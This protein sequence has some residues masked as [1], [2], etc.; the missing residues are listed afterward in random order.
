M[1]ITDLLAQDTFLVVNKKIAKEYGLEVSI[2]L[3]ELAYEYNYWKDREQLENDYFYSTI[4]NIQENTTLT[5]YQQTKALNK[6]KELN[7]IDYKIQGIPPKRYIKVYSDNIFLILENKKSN[8]GKTKVKNWKIKSQKLETNNNNI[9][10]INNNN[11]KYKNFTERDLTDLD[12]F[13]KNI[14]DN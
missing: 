2:M 3:S 9:K 5:K 11:K 10:I 14:G 13:Y 12:K 8:I 4:E 6:L 7:I 1:N